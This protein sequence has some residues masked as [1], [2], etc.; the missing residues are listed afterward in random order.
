MDVTED[1]LNVLPPVPVPNVCV[2]AVKPPRDCM[3]DEPAPAPVP[4]ERTPE[5]LVVNTW[6]LVPSPVGNVQMIL[7]DNVPALK[8]T[9]FAPFA[10]ASAE[11]ITNVLP[12]PAPPVTTKAP[13]AVDV[14]LVG[15]LNV[16]TPE[17]P[18]AP[19]TSS[20]YCGL[21][22]PTPTL[23]PYSARPTTP[24]ASTLMNGTP[25]TSLT[26][27]MVPDVRLLSMT[28]N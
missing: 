24:V 25:D 10:N 15:L 23:P 18:I 16:P 5:P 8:P 3:P 6:P 22:V 28:N 21:V 9:Q 11:P 27:N 4:Q 14:A 13:V 19:L 7:P 20:L 17:T 12:I 1:I 26:L 2:D